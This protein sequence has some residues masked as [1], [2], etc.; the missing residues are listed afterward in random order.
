MRISL[1]KIWPALYRVAE[2][3]LCGLEM[4]NGFYASVLGPKTMANNGGYEESS[5]VVEQYFSRSR[6]DKVQASLETSVHYF[7]GKR[8]DLKYGCAFVD[9]LRDNNFKRILW[10][11]VCLVEYGRTYSIRSGTFVCPRL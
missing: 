8:V 1:P 9:H 4:R 6:G 11:L 7:L 5:R 2:E 10:R 3:D